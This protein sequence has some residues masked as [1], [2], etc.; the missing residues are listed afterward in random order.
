MTGRLSLE[1]IDQR[2]SKATSEMIG[3]C[4]GIEEEQ[5]FYQP[6]DKW[7]IAQN[8]QHLII[9]A[10]KTKLAYNLPKFFLKLYMG[11]ANRPSRPYDELVAKYKLKLQQGGSASKAFRPETIP[12]SAGKLK[13][14][15]EFS[16][17]M[18]HLAEIINTKWSEN[19]LDLYI[20]PHPLLGK[21]TLRELCY[22]TIHHIYH[23]QETI[24]KRLHEFELTR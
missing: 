22:F 9:S 19:N 18:T 4:S 15:Q 11:N 21:I 8:V 17:V 13:I 10:K 2:L 20:A 7:S 16:K 14:L 24:R 3:F 1:E 6:S 23:H 12:S 5:F